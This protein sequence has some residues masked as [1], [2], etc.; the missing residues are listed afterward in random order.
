MTP[1]W[2]SLAD[3]LLPAVLLLA[4]LVAQL[5]ADP[6]P[7]VTFSNSPFTD[8]A[9]NV[10]GARNWILLGDW[11]AGDWALHLVQLPFNALEA[12][13]FAMLGVGIVQARLV[14]ALCSVAA[15]A[16]TTVIVRRR[17]GTEAGL[18][19]GLG[20]AGA[21]LV[22]YY[23]RLAYV[24]TLVMFALVA[25]VAALCWRPSGG[26]G[27]SA[28][29]AGGLLAVAI[30]TKPSALFAVVGILVGVAL[31]T[32][33]GTWVRRTMLATGMVAL[34]AVGWVVLIALPN[35]EPVG[36]VL[37]IWTSQAPPRG[38]AELL[39]R[40][41]DYPATSDGVLLMSLPL[42]IGGVGGL[43]AAIA[44][45]RT[46]DE[47]QRALAGAAIGWFLVGLGVL[48]IAS[49]RPNR[50]SMPMLPALAILTAYLVPAVRAGLQRLGARRLALPLMGTAVTVLLL[51]GLVMYG[52]WASAATSRAPGI[53]AQMA[54]AIDDRPVEGGLAPLFAMRAPVPIH[55]RWSTSEV[56]RGDL[57]ADAGVRWL[58]MA[59]AYRPSWVDLHPEAWEGRTPVLCFA[60]GRG[61]HCLVHLP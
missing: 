31:A 33:R 8:E 20:L 28:A 25:G 12:V 49:Y 41:A 34:A 46:L 36:W 16:V 19:A 1:R 35:A 17:L 58:V 50:Y 6:A 23:G 22:L 30:G 47:G 14:A 38:L 55:V 13:G 40:I 5:P 61:T 11:S 42:V 9:W 29:V 51:P 57:Y 44:R 52:G 48:L 18:F 26:A 37:D 7:G 43:V 15:V 60:W 10:M 27:W 39:R 32:R 59:D 53:Q 2:T 45:W 24:E 54:A 56:N 4:L 3:I 21:G